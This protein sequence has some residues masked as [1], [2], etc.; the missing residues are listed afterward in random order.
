MA[1]PVIGVVSGTKSSD[2]IL[3]ASLSKHFSETRI[4]RYKIP[5]SKWIPWI[6]KRMR[7]L[8]F[9]V[10]VG[11]VLLSGWLRGERCVERL[12]G[13]SI[14]KDFG[15]QPPMWKNVNLL[16]P[17]CLNEDTLIKK[18]QN[19]DL[20]VL[21]DSVRLSH[22]FFRQINVPVVQVVWGMVPEYEGDSGAFWAFAKGEKEKVG[23][24]IV[25]RNG[26][27]HQQQLLVWKPIHTENIDTLRTIKVKQVLALTDILP[28]TL[29][30]FIEHSKT[31]TYQHKKINIRNWYAPTLFTYFLFLVIRKKWGILPIPKYAYRDLEGILLT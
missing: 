8:G 15:V 3:C 17:I 5:F 31:Q 24:S 21:T 28:K 7:F 12:R 2:G 13:K 11:H 22:R 18:L 23:V 14:W 9:F 1:K 10:L 6:W 26:Q 25:V 16:F 4:I 30:D 27:F 20:I 29:Q 19:V